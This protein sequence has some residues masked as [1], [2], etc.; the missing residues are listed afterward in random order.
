MTWMKR[1]ESS[2][3]DDPRDRLAVIDQRIA[4]MRALNKTHGDQLALRLIAHAETERGE[5]LAQI[6]AANRKLA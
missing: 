5:L 6:S 2:A 3:S 1:Y 4:R